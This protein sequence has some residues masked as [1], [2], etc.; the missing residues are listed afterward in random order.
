M[1]DSR[2]E[3]IKE[4][5]RQDQ[6]R[7]R[8]IHATFNRCTN[9][10]GRATMSHKPQASQ[11]SP[12]HREDGDLSLAPRAALFGLVGGFYEVPPLVPTPMTHVPLNRTPHCVQMV[13]A[14][15]LPWG[16]PWWQGPGAHWRAPR[17]AGR[18]W[19]KI[20]RK[21]GRGYLKEIATPFAPSAMKEV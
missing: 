2:L 17:S 10:H 14:D 4:A 13:A 16:D 15:M 19:A 11:D 9:P 3:N 18:H 6:A 8:R 5:K 12:A 1:Q 7:L 21:K 20:G